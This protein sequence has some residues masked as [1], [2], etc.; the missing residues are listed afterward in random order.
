MPNHISYTHKPNS[1]PTLPIK[2]KYP[3]ATCVLRV[4]NIA[5]NIVGS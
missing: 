5:I 3:Q 2:F 4:Q 1:A